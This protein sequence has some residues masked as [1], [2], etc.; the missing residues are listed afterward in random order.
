MS[1]ALY[2][3]VGPFYA[4]PVFFGWGILYRLCYF[5]PGLIFYIAC[6]V[7]FRLPKISVCVACRVYLC[8]WCLSI[9]ARVHRAF[10][11]VCLVVPFFSLFLGSIFASS[12]IFCFLFFF[13][14]VACVLKHFRLVP[15]CIVVVNAVC[16]SYLRLANAILLHLFP[17]LVLGPGAWVCFLPLD[18]CRVLGSLWHGGIIV[19][20][21]WCVS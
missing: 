13:F 1:R 5:H 19:L 3:R 12:S 4:R 2:S 16:C 8:S 15:V 18:A 6:F 10:P 9:Y 20:F 7:L 14:C 17:S 11:V 21:V